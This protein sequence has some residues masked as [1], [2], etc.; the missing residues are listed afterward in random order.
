VDLEERFNSCKCFVS[1]KCPAQR[2]ME[3]AYLVPQLLD[4]RE[5]SAYENLCNCER[6]CDPEPKSKLAI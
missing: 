6:D 3:R 4:P 1:G 2:L 5:L